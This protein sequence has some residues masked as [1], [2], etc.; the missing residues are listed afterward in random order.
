MRSSGKSNC[1]EADGWEAWQLEGHT[2]TVTAIAFMPDRFLLA[3]ASEDGSICLWESAE[4]LVQTLSGADDGFSCLAWQLQGQFLA[5]GGHNGE[6]LIWA[7]SFA[8][9]R[10]A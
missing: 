5:G 3:S 10:F 8:G 7:K 9:Q 6:L 1:L 4:R 2:E